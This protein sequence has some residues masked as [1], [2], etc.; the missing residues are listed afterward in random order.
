MRKVIV[1]LSLCSVLSAQEW[2]DKRPNWLTDDVEHQLN[3]TYNGYL[4]W[5][6]QSGYWIQID[7]G[8]WGWYELSDIDTLIYQCD[9]SCYRGGSVM[10]NVA[11]RWWLDYSDLSMYDLEY[12][13]YCV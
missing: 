11:P 1:L 3:G 7:C 6:D 12:M 4:D 13:G 8:L 10:I 5:S 9:S 2:T